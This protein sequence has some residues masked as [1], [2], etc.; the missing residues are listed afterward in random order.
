MKKLCLSVLLAAVSMSSAL[1]VV[2]S[3]ND[4]VGTSGGIF[5][6]SFRIST[7]RSLG[8]NGFKVYFYFSNDVANEMPL[9]IPEKTGYAADAKKIELQRVSSHVWRVML[10]FSNTNIPSN[11]YYPSS[12]TVFFTALINGANKYNH[13]LRPY[14]WGKGFHNAV[15]ESKDGEILDGQHPNLRSRVG[16]LSK[17]GSVCKSGGNTFG[18]TTVFQ[19]VMISL[20]SEKSGCTS[21]I[22][23]PIPNGVYVSGRN[24]NFKYCIYEFDELPRVSYDYAVLRLD[25]NCPIGSIPFSRTHDT[26]NSNGS[27]TVIGPAWPNVIGKDVTLE[28]CFVPKDPNATRVYPLDGTYTSDYNTSVFANVNKPNLAVSTLHVDDEDSGRSSDSWYYYELSEDKTNEKKIIDRMKIIMDG[29]DNTDYHLVTRKQNL[30][31]SAEVADVHNSVNNSYVAIAPLAPAIK[32]LNRSAVAV[33][34]QSAGDAKISIAG[35]N[36]VVVANITEKN[37]QPGVHQIKWNAGM[38]PSGRYV[39]KIEQNG[40]V[41]AKNVI[42]K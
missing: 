32:G 19:D 10:D 41:N 22:S 25:E 2:G 23:G 27:N 11:S 13:A 4:Q 26:E 14:P 39:V 9:F 15:V 33:E 35:I 1:T 20:N 3:P 24:V 36:G 5:S 6:P 37:L 38:V 28:Y 17:N 30:A 7:Q 18:G 8:V 21:A 34:L 31:K 16:I 12:P 40:M 42:L 29:S